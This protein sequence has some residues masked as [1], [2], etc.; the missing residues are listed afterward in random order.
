MRGLVGWAWRDFRRP[1]DL[2]KLESDEAIGVMENFLKIYYHI[3]PLSCFHFCFSGNCE[4]EM[5]LYL[6]LRMV[7]LYHTGIKAYESKS[8]V[9]YPKVFR[10]TLYL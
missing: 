6:C 9:L 5:F 1:V 8:F 7:G 4:Q 3:F 10:F 2:R